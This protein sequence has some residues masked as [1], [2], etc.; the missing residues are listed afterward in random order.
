[1]TEKPIEKEKVIRCPWRSVA[2]HAKRRAPKGYYFGHAR[3]LDANKCFGKK[4]DRVKV[5]AWVTYV[6]KEAPE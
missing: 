2:F 6:L 1:M 3:N 4:G 5:R